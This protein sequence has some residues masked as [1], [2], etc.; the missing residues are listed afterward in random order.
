MPREL[1]IW[2]SIITLSFNVLAATALPVEAA[3]TSRDGQQM[4]VCAASGMMVLGED[5]TLLPSKPAPS[6]GSLCVFCL[7]LVHGAVNVP[8]AFG[9][10]EPPTTAVVPHFAAVPDNPV[11]RSWRLEGASTPR[12]PPAA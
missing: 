11:L 5:D 9:L 3:G 7:P 6:H 10:A 2:L 8:M 1:L 12:G 4:V